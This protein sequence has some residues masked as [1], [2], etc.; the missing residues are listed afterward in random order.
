MFDRALSGGAQALGRKTGR[1]EIGHRADFLVLDAEM[2]VMT[3]KLRDHVIDTAVFGCDDNPVRDVMVGGRWA[4][5][6]RHH[7]REE[8]ILEKYRRTM[9]K[10]KY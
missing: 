4:V 6:N 8:Q 2:P 7:K 9:H 1:I 3:G 10:F 5:R